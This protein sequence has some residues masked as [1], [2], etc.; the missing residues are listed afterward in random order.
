MRYAFVLLVYYFVA[1][2]PCNE[3]RSTNEHGKGQDCDRLL[4][5]WTEA[6]A[7]P[8]VVQHRSYHCDVRFSICVRFDV[9]LSS[10]LKKGLT[11]EPTDIISAMHFF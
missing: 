7:C 6:S 11:S 2:L 5:N 10:K 8:V 9:P 1:G 4:L 3:P